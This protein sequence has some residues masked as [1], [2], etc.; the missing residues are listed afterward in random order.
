MRRRFVTLGLLAALTLPM[1]A[2]AAADLNCEVQFLVNAKWSEIKTVTV[3]F[4]TGAELNKA[5]GTFHF[6]PLK[7]YAVIPTGVTDKA[8]VELDTP[9]TVTGLTFTQSD[10]TTF[11]ATHHDLTGW[12]AN[13]KLM[14][15]WSLKPQWT[16]NTF[17][18]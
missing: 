15:K 17:Q 12:Q 2:L 8:I 13:G 3:T 5:S 10:L 1:P 14:V 18:R 7:A 11:V 4:M 16:G 9:T 6:P